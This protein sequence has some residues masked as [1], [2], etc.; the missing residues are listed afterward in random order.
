MLLALISRAR[1]QVLK[2][3][4]ATSVRDVCHVEY[5]AVE[6][7]KNRIWNPMRPMWK[8]DPLNSEP[9]EILHCQIIG[10][11]DLV[12]ASTSSRR[13]VLGHLRAP[14]TA[15][16]NNVAHFLEI[17]FNASMNHDGPIGFSNKA[18]RSTK[19]ASINTWRDDRL[20]EIT[21]AHTR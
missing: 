7:Q 21:S 15:V 11:M 12:K 20:S 18:L 17:S 19:P 10:R 4:P 6:L 2:G 8:K 1:N 9:R 14:R 13:E 3:T 5:D 16:G